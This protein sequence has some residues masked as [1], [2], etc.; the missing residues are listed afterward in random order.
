[1][2]KNGIIRKKERGN[3]DEKSVKPLFEQFNDIWTGESSN[4]RC[5]KMLLF[6]SASAQGA[7]KSQKVF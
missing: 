5:N 6:Y 4:R 1:V 2:S 7:G 3:Q